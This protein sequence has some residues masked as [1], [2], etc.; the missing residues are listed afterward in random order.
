MSETC[1]CQGCEIKKRASEIYNNIQAF[2]KPSIEEDKD[3][4]EWHI[5][6]LLRIVQ[7]SYPFHFVEVHIKLKNGQKNFITSIIKESPK[8]HVL[9]F[10]SF[11]NVTKIMNEQAD[12]HKK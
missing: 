5:A 2:I 4:E 6:N 9:S 10:V 3:I 12:G 1:T 7:A 11:M 8:Q